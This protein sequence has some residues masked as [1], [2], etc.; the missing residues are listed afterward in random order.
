MLCGFASEHHWSDSMRNILEP[1]RG[2]TTV[3]SEHSPPPFP[4]SPPFLLHFTGRH[5][6]RI[7][8]WVPASSVVLCSKTLNMYCP[9]DMSFLTHAT[10]KFLFARFK[11]QRCLELATVQSV[12]PFPYSLDGGRKLINTTGAIF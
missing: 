3:A 10:S 11:L 2:L 9:R 1:R 6:M 4:S 5:L 12:H 8:N 7:S